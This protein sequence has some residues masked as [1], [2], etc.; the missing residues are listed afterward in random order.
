MV[1]I[2]AAIPRKCVSP[3]L[4]EPGD[5]ASR[6]G[7]GGI[8][9]PRG[10]GFTLVEL[11]VVITI[12]GI[13]VAMLLPAVQAARESGRRT[14]CSNNL[15]QLANACLQHEQ[16]RGFF[17]TGGWGWGWTG[18]ADRGADIGQSGG[19][20]YNI[21]PYIDQQ[22]LHD[23]GAG[24]T[25]AQKM[26]SNA[27]RV[28]TPLSAF[29]CP[30]R[31]RAIACPYTS[32]TPANY[33]IPAAGVAKSDYG[34]NNGTTNCLPSGYGIWPTN[35]GNGDCGP[36][37]NSAPTQTTL[38]QLASQISTS[39]SPPNGIIY[40]LSRV[41][42]AQI[43]DGMSNTYLAAEKY[44]DPDL[45]AT[46]TDSGDNEDAFIGDNSDVS[47]GVYSPPLPDT[48]GYVAYVIFGSAHPGTFQAALCDGSVRSIAFSINPAVHIL[49][50]NRQ[51]GMP[52]DPSGF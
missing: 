26:V 19:W 15:K 2:Q 22:A 36:P 47:R 46:G 18:D 25:A 32:E 39:A 33:N 3:P 7:Q 35:C 5:A 44:L 13:L 21:L 24:Q 38:L 4:A 27:T 1:A 20:L 10:L 52:I 48:P 29:N 40:P 23:L 14:Y 9:H 17:P 42:S 49:L 28:Q 31:R 30:S 45:Y 6:K 16:G 37:I 50:G 41:A 8:S 51:D 12:I 34:G 43:K 11:L